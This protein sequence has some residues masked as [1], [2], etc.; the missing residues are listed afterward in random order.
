[1]VSAKYSVSLFDDKGIVLLSVPIVEGIGSTH[2]RREWVGLPGANDRFHNAP[3]RLVI[4][5]T[6]NVS[7]A[8]SSLLT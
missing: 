4:A 3:Y 6:C 8:Q 7:Q 5:A 2:V 1:M